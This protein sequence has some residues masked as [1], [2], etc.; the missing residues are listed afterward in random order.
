[1]GITIK[2][3]QNIGRPISSGVSGE[4]NEQKGPVGHIK[5]MG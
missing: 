3:G 1:M 4:F 2:L 5:Y